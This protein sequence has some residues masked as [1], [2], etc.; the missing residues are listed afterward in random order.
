MYWLSH[1]QTRIQQQLR[2]KWANINFWRLNFIVFLAAKKKKHFTIAFF[3]K[4]ILFLYVYTKLHDDLYF[5]IF[6]LRVRVMKSIKSNLGYVLKQNGRVKQLPKHLL[7]IVVFLGNIPPNECSHFTWLSRG[8]FSS[9][10]RCVNLAKAIMGDGERR[11]MDAMSA[12]AFENRHGIYAA[13]NCPTQMKR[14]R[15]PAHLYRVTIIRHY[16]YWRWS[17]SDRFNSCYLAFRH[18]VTALARDEGYKSALSAAVVY[19]VVLV[20]CLRGAHQWQLLQSNSLT[21]YLMGI[22]LHAKHGLSIPS[23][24]SEGRQLLRRALARRGRQAFCHI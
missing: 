11:L 2:Y 5:T 14:R 6:F 17:A 20:W 15:E 9:S 1:G 7:A 16:L 8:S 13:A 12:S 22:G 23:G 10:P 21:A 19:S 24:K 18:Y 3:C 4:N